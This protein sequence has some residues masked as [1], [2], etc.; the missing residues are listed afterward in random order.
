MKKQGENKMKKIILAVMILAMTVG[1]V[2]AKCTDEWTKED[3]IMQGL[4]LGTQY[5][6]YKQNRE[7]AEDRNFKFD[8]LKWRPYNE[9]VDQFHI[10]MA[11]IHTMVSYY[12]P[13]KYR[14]A[15]QG[16]TLGL[17]LI[18][19]DDHRAAGVSLGWSF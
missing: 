4:N 18:S 14:T 9:D 11:V 2:Q 17:T 10:A 16:S 15:W 5:I 12:I 13:C 6:L 1:T 8:G 19:I 7:V 3:T